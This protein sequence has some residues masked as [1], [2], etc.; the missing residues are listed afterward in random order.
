M[1]RLGRDANLGHWS[2]LLDNILF[3][4]NR[5]ANLSISKFVVAFCRVPYKIKFALRSSS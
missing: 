1:L 5:N 4:K 2:H 3:V